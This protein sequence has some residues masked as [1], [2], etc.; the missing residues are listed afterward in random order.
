MING[1]FTAIF[2]GSPPAITSDVSLVRGYRDE[3]D[4]SQGL[5][6][7]FEPGDPFVILNHAVSTGGNSP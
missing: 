3:K 6:M 5:R 4:Y 7:N 2:P 1:I